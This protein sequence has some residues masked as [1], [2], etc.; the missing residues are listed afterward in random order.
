MNS[1]SLSHWHR[2]ALKRGRPKSRHH[3]FSTS[4]E[5]SEWNHD[6]TMCIDPRIRPQLLF[7]RGIVFALKPPKIT[8]RGRSPS[9]HQSESHAVA[10]GQRARDSGARLSIGAFLSIK[11]G[12]VL[13][14][15]DFASRLHSVRALPMS[16]SHTCFQL[17]VTNEF[18][19]VQRF[20]RLPNRRVRHVPNQP[21]ILRRSH[22]QGSICRL[23]CFGSPRNFFLLLDVSGW[24]RIVSVCCWTCHG[25]M[26]CLNCWALSE[27]SL[28]FLLLNLCRWKHFFVNAGRSSAENLPKKA[29]RRRMQ[30]AA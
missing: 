4:N 15:G 12:R 2:S 16:R 9:C 29:R 21:R 17:S 13:C 6:P 11:E 26:W 18:V 7:G 19:K 14:T 5:G 3:R 30:H 28:C 1:V 24:K 22:R 23:M 10:G 8:R 20:A 27:L 25:G